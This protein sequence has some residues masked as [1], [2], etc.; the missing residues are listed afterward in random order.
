[1]RHRLLPVL[2][3]GLRPGPARN[4]GSNQRS[5]VRI[6]RADAYT[7]ARVLS[8]PHERHLKLGPEVEPA[9]D[10]DAD[11]DQHHDGSESDRDAGDGRPEGH[12]GYTPPRAHRGYMIARGMAIVPPR[13]S[14]RFLPSE[15]RLSVWMFCGAAIITLS[16]TVL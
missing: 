2:L 8:L 16:P 5:T 6:A 12:G 10:D 7:Q 9:N 1:M 3:P 11:S 13:G 4:V 14:P 15:N